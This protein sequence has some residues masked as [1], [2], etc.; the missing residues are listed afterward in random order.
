M[1]KIWTRRK[2][3]KL[4][5]RDNEVGFD[6]DSSNTYAGEEEQDHGKPH[7]F[8]NMLFAIN[9]VVMDDILQAVDDEKYFCILMDSSTDSGRWCELSFVIRYWERREKRMKN[10]MLQ[11]R[12]IGVEGETAHQLKKMLLEVLKEHGLDKKYL[13]AIGT[14]GASNMTGKRDGLVALLKK[15]DGMDWLIGVHCACHKVH[16]AA[17]ASTNLTKKEKEKGV[18][19]ECGEM[20]A[21]RKDLNDIAHFA[22]KSPLRLRMMERADDEITQRKEKEERQ[23]EQKEEDDGK[24]KKTGKGEKQKG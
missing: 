6:D 24:K 22:H 1:M 3:N 11:L 14:D 5:G 17:Q 15:E 12:R 23:E 13:L 2:K 7:H 9:D 4:I 16:L 10:S 20:G 19:T 21:V 8:T 18:D